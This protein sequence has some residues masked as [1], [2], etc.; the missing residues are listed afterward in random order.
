MQNESEEKWTYNKL[1]KYDIQT[2]EQT[3]AKA[4]SDLT[5]IELDC[6]IN[7]INYDKRSLSYSSAKFDVSLSEIFKEFDDSE[8]DNAQTL[9]SI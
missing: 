5:G 4:V 7:H 9:K 2:L 3:I 8:N 1:K 6:S